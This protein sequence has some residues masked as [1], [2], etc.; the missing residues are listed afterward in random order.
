MSK[1]KT[2]DIWQTTAANQN[3]MADVTCL[4]LIHTVTCIH[5]YRNKNSHSFIFYQSHYSDCSLCC[6]FLQLFHKQLTHFEIKWKKNTLP[7]IMGCTTLTNGGSKGYVS[8][9][10]MFRSMASLPSFSL[11]MAKSWLRGLSGSTAIKRMFH[12]YKESFTNSI[13][14]IL[15][16]KVSDLYMS[17]NSFIS[18]SVAC[19]EPET[20]P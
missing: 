4:H 11:S 3:Q 20:E 17:L 1:I 19:T 12:S 14:Y 5:H 7:E 16:L 2:T 15:F 6:W 9:K 8:L 13:W 18:L 10:S